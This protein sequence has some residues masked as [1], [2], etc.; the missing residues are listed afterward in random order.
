MRANY[1]ASKNDMRKIA[2]EEAKKQLDELRATEC[3]RCQTSIGFQ[4]I[5]TV[6]MV[7]HRQ[8]GFGRKRLQALK[9]AVETEFYM[10]DH[11]V[12]GVTKRRQYTGVDFV[13]KLKEMGVDLEVS[14]YERE[15]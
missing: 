10:M 11:G 1:V 7:L 3:E 14:Q 2:T 15:G 12:P 9:D 8:Y 5:A 13:A 4:A 6:M